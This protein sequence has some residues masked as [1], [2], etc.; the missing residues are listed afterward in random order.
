MDLPPCLSLGPSLRL[1]WPG[2]CVG[3]ALPPLRGPRGWLSVGLGVCRVLRLCLA[4]RL[5]PLLGCSAAT[6]QGSR[7]CLI[8]R[9]CLLAYGA[10][11]L[12]F[13]ILTGGRGGGRGVR[14]CGEWAPL[15]GAP[16]SSWARPGSTQWDCALPP[17]PPVSLSHGE[18]PGLLA[19]GGLSSPGAGQGGARGHS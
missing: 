7:G 15:T 10:G 5:P 14:A 6:G 19:R 18:G 3:T 17:L 1:W 9:H 16:P 11:S 13:R 4:L 12:L 8:R 2:L